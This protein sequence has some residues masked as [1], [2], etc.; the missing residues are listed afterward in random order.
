MMDVVK[1]TRYREGHGAMGLGGDRGD[2]EGQ[3]REI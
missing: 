3:E 1:Y 2:P